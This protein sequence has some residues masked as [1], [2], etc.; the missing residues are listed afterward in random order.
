MWCCKTCTISGLVLLS[1]L[2]FYPELFG[3]LWICVLLAIASGILGLVMLKGE[4][5]NGWI[6]IAASAF[7]II[8]YYPAFNKTEQMTLFMKFVFAVML[9]AGG[10]FSIMKNSGGGIFNNSKLKE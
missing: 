5:M 9:I 6:I 10:E 4:C 7:L 3:S 8:S 2:Y 1:G